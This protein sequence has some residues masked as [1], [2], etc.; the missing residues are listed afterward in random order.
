MSSLSLEQI[1][2]LHD[3]L[4]F[5]RDVGVV[6]IAKLRHALLKVWEYVCESLWIIFL[7]F[8]R[9]EFNFRMQMSCL[10]QSLLYL[11]F[12]KW[13]GSLVLRL[14]AGLYFWLCLNPFTGLWFLGLSSRNFISF[15]STALV[16]GHWMPLS[17][18][19]V[20][21]HLSMSSTKLVLNYYC[22]LAPFSWL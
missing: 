13:I 22:C 8:I 14:T 9:K 3:K 4:C 17:E 10:G 15:C 6:L 5:Q 2:F 1:V 11:P 20:P 12:W 7:I 18:R 21:A 16:I 19:Y